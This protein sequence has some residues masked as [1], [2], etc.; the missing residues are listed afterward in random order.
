MTFT[1]IVFIVQAIFA[2][3]FLTTFNIEGLSILIIALT[4]VF[5]L[6]DL[7]RLELPKMMFNLLFVSY[8]LRLF[9]MFF[10]LYGQDIFVLPNS[11]LDSEM[12]HGS[13]LQGLATGNYGNGHVYSMVLGFIYTFFGN[14]RMVAQFFN[15]LLSVQAILL[16]YKTMDLY[17]IHDKV[18]FLTISLLALIPNFAI[19]S[20]ILLRESIIIFLYILSFYYFSKWFT[21]NNLWLLII[22]YAFGLLVAVFHSGSIILVVAYTVI[23][24]LY[25]HTKEQFN[26]SLKSVLIAST[27]SLV[28]LFIF[29]NYFDLF[30][31]KFSN[32]DEMEDV[33]DIYV[34]GASGY[35]TGYPIENPV[36]NFIVNTPLRIFSFV[37]SPLPWNWRGVTDVIAFTFSSLFYGGGLYLG[38][39]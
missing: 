30:F 26:L 25:D 14:E 10:D 37:F 9:L 13:A 3:I 39:C 24:I 5:L 15:V 35:S 36:F 17:H 8:L 2:H 20:S 11:G 18:K 21:Q 7:S 22:S 19:M 23:L 38:V 34:M 4:S 28:F 1:W 33:T 27:F 6:F 12:F 16:V 29:Q 32:I 31:L